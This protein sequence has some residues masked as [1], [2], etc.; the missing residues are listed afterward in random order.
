MH[1]VPILTSPLLM[2]DFGF[3]HWLVLPR[4]QVFPNYEEERSAVLDFSA[5]LHHNCFP[6]F[7]SFFGG[8]FDLAV[9]LASLVYQRCRQSLVL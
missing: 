5:E 8:N 2:L 7:P 1:F 9:V 6:A 4:A 3:K